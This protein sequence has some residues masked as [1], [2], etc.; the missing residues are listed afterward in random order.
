MGRILFSLRP[1]SD[2]TKDLELDPGPQTVRI[3][4]IQQRITKK[5]TRPLNAPHV[6]ELAE[7]I[8]IL[9]LLE[10][11]VIDRRGNL[12][13][14]AHRLAALQLLITSSDEAREKD[15]IKRLETS[16]RSDG[17]MEDGGPQ[18]YKDLVERVRFLGSLSSHATSTRDAPVLVVDVG[19]DDQASERRRLA[20]EVAENNVR[21][22]YS[23]DE[24]KALA[25]RLKA[26]G[27]KANPGRRKVGAPPTVINVLQAAVGRSRR[28]IE[29]I[30]RNEPANEKTPWENARQTLLRAA[31]RL[32]E[33][34]KGR[35]GEADRKLLAAAIAII[36]VDDGAE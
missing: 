5:D 9:G 18:G 14:G 13:A 15:F 29:R 16:T 11:L 7:S 36:N 25:M 35:R 1:E 34:G 4:H 30:I 24:I 3:E 21:R 22:P 10:P 6:V 32:V 33:E 12:L 28:T 19:D 27:Y 20:I 17:A 26:A 8:A 23:A 2:G 31:H